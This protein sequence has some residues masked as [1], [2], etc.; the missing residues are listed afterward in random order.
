MK[1]ID[2]STVLQ[3][4][5]LIFLVFIGYLTFK[6]SSNWSIIKSELENAR[7]ELKISRDTLA[8][9]KFKL[10]KSVQTIDKLQL[11]KE[12]YALQRDSI[13]LALKRKNAK[14]WDELTTLKDSINTINS[15]I[16]EDL[17]L[18]KKVYGL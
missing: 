4:I 16:S 11:Q 17:A 18:L 6:S 2:L 5:A 12:V 9:T 3:I 8:A 7:K 10:E 1:K 15:K 13:I 14:N